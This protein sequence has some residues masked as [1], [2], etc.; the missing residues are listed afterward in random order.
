MKQIFISVKGGL[1]NQLFQAALGIALERSLGVT[2]RFLTNS[3]TTDTHGRSYLLDAF[4][5]LRNRGVAAGSLAGVKLL[6]EEQ[7]A[8]LA[9]EHRVRG[10][11]SILAT[12]DN[13]ALDGYWQDERYWNEHGDVIRDLLRPDV[14]QRVLEAGANV[15]AAGAIGMHVRRGDYG[16]HGLARSEY[17]LRSLAAIRAETGASSALYAT[18]EPNFCRFEFRGIPDLVQLPGETQ[19]PFD[20]FYLLSCCRH[21]V[22]ANSSFSWWAA[23]LGE[24]PGSIVYVPQP[25]CIFDPALNPAPPRWR[26]V[27]GA[28]QRQ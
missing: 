20:D 8:P 12:E 3:F 28:V 23:F 21:F 14:S 19:K 2:V 10:I 27:A 4:A 5:A 13:L 24:Q 26:N 9:P 15:R 16:H 25:W 6:N 18:D 7:L 1:G 11:A 17:Y 22:I